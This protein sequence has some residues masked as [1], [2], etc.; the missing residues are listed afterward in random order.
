M[1]RWIFV[2]FLAAAAAHAADAEG[3]KDHPLVS[4]VPGYDL[5]ECPSVDFDEKEFNT[6][7]GPVRVGGRTTTLTYR[8]GSGPARS[9]AF[10]TK[11]YAAALQ[12]SGFSPELQN[13]GGAEI[14]FSLKKSGTE[15]WVSASGYFGEGTPEATGAYMVI[16]VE[17]AGMQQVVS[18]KD[19][20]DEI[21]RTGRAA[22]AVQFD[23]GKD[24]IRPESAPLVKA[25]ADLLTST[26][27]LKVYVVGHTDLQGDLQA[28]LTLS[29]ARAASVVKALTTTHGIAANRL[30]PHGVGPL[31][32]IATNDTEAGRAQNRR[33]E[34]VKR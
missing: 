31:S 34:L 23:S 1:S 4:R 11:N 9:M 25:M 30:A 18:A 24:T 7:K 5:T 17:K 6:K 29:S 26:P 20:S 33:V 8:L 22:L 19:L 2:A 21:A 10:V 3:C 32:P 15:A 28:N 16:I 12:K 13:P 27:S 14:V